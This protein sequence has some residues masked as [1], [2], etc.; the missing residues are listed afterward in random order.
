MVYDSWLLMSQSVQWYASSTVAACAYMYALDMSP[1]LHVQCS[2]TTILP[3]HPLLLSRIIISH[4]PFII[5]VHFTYLSIFHTF[6]PDSSTINSATTKHK[7]CAVISKHSTLPLVPPTH[8]PTSKLSSLTSHLNLNTPL[9]YPTL[10]TASIPSP[11]GVTVAL[12]PR[13][14]PSLANIGNQTATCHFL[15]DRA[16]CIRATPTQGTHHPLPQPH[17][18]PSEQTPPKCEYNLFR[19]ITSHPLSALSVPSS[20]PSSHPVRPCVTTMQQDTCTD[21]S[22]TCPGR[23]SPYLSSRPTMPSTRSSSTLS[24]RLDSPSWTSRPL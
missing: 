21:L 1:R 8:H 2:Q 9:T 20:A 10:T 6:D 11:P 22:L 18:I 5:A 19:F 13:A 14:R 24:F 15:S 17:P 3:L 16:T 4:V 23:G 12:V 7:H